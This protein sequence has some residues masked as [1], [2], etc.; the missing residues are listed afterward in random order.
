M[1]S[2]A[3][4]QD[5]KIP[6]IKDITL[7][8]FLGL[9]LGLFSKIYIPLFFTPVPIVLQNSIA[10]VY[11]YIFKSKK[12]F[13]SVL[14]FILL[15]GLGLPFFSKGCGF[16]YLISTNAGYIFGYLI[17]AFIVG[18]IIEKN[19]FYRN[20]SLKNIFF[21]ILLGHL[22]VLFCGWLWFSTF[23]GIKKAFML[24]VLPFIAGDIFKTLAIVK[25]IKLKILN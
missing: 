4:N 7:V 22:T 24:G 6:F 14:L 23:I 19:D 2:L 18:K 25:L 16:A 20:F 17:A 5:I 13:L 11:G 9:F 1:K 12:A 3:I 10:I 21:I 8:I 15:G